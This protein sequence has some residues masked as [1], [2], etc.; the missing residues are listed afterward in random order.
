MDNGFLAILSSLA[1]IAL[2]IMTKHSSGE[3]GWKPL[4]KY[5]LFFVLLGLISLAIGVY[6]SMV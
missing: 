1:I 3:D 2:G 4:K 6:K 5:W